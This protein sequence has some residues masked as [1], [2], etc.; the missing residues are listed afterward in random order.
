MCVENG[1][2]MSSSTVVEK[3]RSALLLGTSRSALLSSTSRSTLLSSASRS[4][5]LSSTLR[6]ACTAVEYVEISN[7]RV[8]EYVEI[9]AALVATNTTVQFRL[10][11]VWLLGSLT[12]CIGAMGCRV[13]R[14]LGWCVGAVAVAPVVLALSPVVL[15]LSLLLSSAQVVVLP[16]W[17]TTVAVSCAG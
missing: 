5:L 15:A 10:C 16:C 14:C 13:W 6:S 11:W 1:R 7:G 2:V 3:S 9:S 12:L 8:D 4:A 17:A